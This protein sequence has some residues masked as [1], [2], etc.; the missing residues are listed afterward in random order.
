MAHE[1]NDERDPH[2]SQ[3]MEPNKY[4]Q[5]V[6]SSAAIMKNR[7]TRET[8]YKK[9]KRKVDQDREIEETRANN[10]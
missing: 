8:H 3:V 6:D 9:R 5:E 2:E 4:Y 10:L 7:K 1:E